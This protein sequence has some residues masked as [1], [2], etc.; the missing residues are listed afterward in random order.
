MPPNSA[1]FIRVP[2][3]KKGCGALDQ[4][5]Q[6]T[7]V[8]SETIIASAE[9]KNNSKAIAASYLLVKGRQCKHADNHH[10]N[11]QVG[12]LSTLYIQC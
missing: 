1:S 5:K 12:L 11:D 9:F 10:T 7:K 3:I 2:Q 8:V 4:C 6:I